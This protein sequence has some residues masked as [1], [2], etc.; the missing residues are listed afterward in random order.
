MPNTLSFNPD[1]ITLDRDSVDVWQYPT[2]PDLDETNPAVQARAEHLQHEYVE[3]LAHD[4][5]FTA[6]TPQLHASTPELRATDPVET[7]VAEAQ[8]VVANAFADP[9]MLVMHQANEVQRTNREHHAEALTRAAAY[10]PRV[11]DMRDRALLDWG[12]DAA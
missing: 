9:D 2:A 3:A 11:N 10:A 1:M 8:A 5:D 7:V 4:E 6:E 12:A